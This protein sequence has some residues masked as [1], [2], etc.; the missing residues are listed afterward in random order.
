MALTAFQL[1]GKTGGRYGLI[2]YGS[3]FAPPC[4]LLLDIIEGFLIDYGFMSVLHPVARQFAVILLPLFGKRT[5]EV[6]LLKKHISCVSDVRK[7]TPDIGINPAASCSGGNPLGGKFPFCFQ[8]RFA[9]EEILKDAL[10]DGGFFWHYHQLVIFPAVAINS[11]ASVGNALLEAFSCT[12]FAVI[13]YVDALLLRKTGQN[14]QHNFARRT[15]GA[16]IFLLG[17]YSNKTIFHD[18]QRTTIYSTILDSKSTK[19]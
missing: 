14:G 1:T 2:G 18:T 17:V 9:I 7:H 4:H 8:S 10:H 12:P 11:E 19:Y 15:R 3:Q 16:D 5:I 6:F 13:G